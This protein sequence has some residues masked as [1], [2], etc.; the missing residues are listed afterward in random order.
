MNKSHDSASGKPARSRT[1]N[2]ALDTIA[3][4]A[5]PEELQR[6]AVFHREAGR[7]EER[8]RCARI[9][10]SYDGATGWAPGKVLAAQIRSGE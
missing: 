10:E 4:S 3:P 6:A 5:S 1:S 9:A 2:L 8:E 7:L